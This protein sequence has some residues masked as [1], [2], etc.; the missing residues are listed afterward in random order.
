MRGITR[1]LSLFIIITTE[2]FRP[3]W[4]A[5][6]LAWHTCWRH[7]IRNWIVWRRKLTSGSKTIVSSWSYLEG[8]QAAPILTAMQTGLARLCLISQITFKVRR[9]ERSSSKLWL[10]RQDENIDDWLAGLLGCRTNDCV[11]VTRSPCDTIWVNK[12]KQLVASMGRD[13]IYLNEMFPLLF[14]QPRSK[15]S[16]GKHFSQ[17]FATLA[18]Q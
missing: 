16:T 13:L 3:R 6:G 4:L 10:R 11:S 1:R 5:N 8:E 9:L 15:T 14:T 18:C 12:C 7:N 17:L 2:S